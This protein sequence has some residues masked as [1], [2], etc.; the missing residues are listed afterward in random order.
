M[1]LENNQP[2]TDRVYLHADDSLLL[3]CSEFDRCYKNSIFS[4]GILTVLFYFFQKRAFSN[5]DVWEMQ[6]L[7]Q[8]YKESLDMYP[9]PSERE[10][11]FSISNQVATHGNRL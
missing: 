11:D 10:S 6:I 5:Q 4:L 1:N 9:A 7:F 2:K 8:S 3:Q